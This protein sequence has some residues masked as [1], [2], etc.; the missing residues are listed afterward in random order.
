MTAIVR[1]ILWSLLFF[2]AAFLFYTT[3]QYLSFRSDINFL[4]VKQDV[5]FDALWRTSFY[6][7]IISAMIIIVI[8]PIQFIKSFRNRY[9]NLHR[10]FGK[11]YAYGILLFAAPS[12]LIMAFFA[13]GGTPSAIAF[14][15]MSLLWFTTTI[16]AI[17]TVRQ[18]KINEH[19]KW[20]MRSYA[21]SFAAV[22]L[23]LLV[24]LFS[25]F[26]FSDGFIIV[27]TAW[28]SWII[29][30]LLTELIIVFTLKKSIQL[31]GTTRE[32]YT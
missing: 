30:L 29:N 27:S 28:L 13:E 4:L 32:S 22:T 20:M 26:Q 23:R 14:I 5:V 15:I 3:V 9:L 18:K 8:G 7:H 1:P 31:S 25:V 2:F 16:M 10:L 19:R 24:P 11:I 12:G 21:L 6:F 17:V